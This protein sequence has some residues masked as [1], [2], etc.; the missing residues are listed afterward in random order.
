VNQKGFG[1]RVTKGD[2]VVPEKHKAIVRERIKN[3]T[4]KDF[5][6]WDEARAQL[7]FKTK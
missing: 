4:P 2:V 7:K 5:I 1:V 6:P 3:T